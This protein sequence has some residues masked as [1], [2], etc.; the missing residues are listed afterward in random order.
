MHASEAPP[1]VPRPPPPSNQAAGAAPIVAA[2]ARK[3]YVRIDPI[4]NAKR[5]VSRAELLR[6]E[7]ILQ[8]KLTQLGAV[9]APNNESSASAETALK[10]MAVPGYRLRLQLSFEAKKASVEMLVT[11]YPS[12]SLKGSWRVSGTNA[13]LSDLIDAIVP[14]VVDLA[15]S[16]LAWK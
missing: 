4:V 8:Q 16:E 7:L 11:T 3:F 15:G 5:T 10:T 2:R 9:V 13:E 12:G 1:P 6:A 14:G